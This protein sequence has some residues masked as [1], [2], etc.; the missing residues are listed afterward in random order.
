V[1]PGLLHRRALPRSA[2]VRADRGDGG[3]DGLLL[4]RRQ[5]L[6]GRIADDGVWSSVDGG[7]GGALR[8]QDVGWKKLGHF[9][10]LGLPEPGHPS[11]PATPPAATSKPT[12]PASANQLPREARRETSKRLHL[13]TAEVDGE[14]ER[15]VAAAP[16]EQL[17]LW[18]ERLLSAATLTELLAG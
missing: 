17:E 1:S 9:G 15:R 5:A 18:G 13:E 8:F 10:S 12:P 6:A 11:P 16:A 7:G 4:L 2:R 3:D 14:I